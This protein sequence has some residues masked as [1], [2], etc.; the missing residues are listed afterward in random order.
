MQLQQILFTTITF[1][2]IVCAQSAQPGRLR[3]F[4]ESAPTWEMTGIG[5]VGP[6]GGGGGFAGGA[7]PQSVEVMK[8]FQE[9][10]PEVQITSRREAADYVVQFDR[11]GGKDLVRRD[12]KIA[13]F[14]KDG[15]LVLTK[16]TRMLGNAVKE[17]C[18]AVLGRPSP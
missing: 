2:G 3:V 18:A 1:A 16:S 12:N 15:D 5:G 8:T 4:I 10:C 9:R 7:R 17:A 6:D 14:R 11:E 13:V